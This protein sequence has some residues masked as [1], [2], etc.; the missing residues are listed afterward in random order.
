MPAIPRH[1]PTC[2]SSSQGTS[3]PPSLGIGQ[4]ALAPKWTK[5]GEL[6]TRTGQA[7]TTTTP[8]PPTP[9]PDGQ[10]SNP[11]P[12]LSTSVPSPASP[13]L[14]AFA[15]TE[16]L[17]LALSLE[18]NQGKDMVLLLTDSMAAYNS[19]LHI[20][21]GR[22]PRSGIEVRLALALASRTHLDTGISWMI[23]HRHPR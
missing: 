1:C 20:A 10:T 8:L 19:A 6:P 11:S 14:K 15:D 3:T 23:T 5:A 17:G 22:A 12:P 2:N 16:R 7:A 4:H 18:A 13:T 21:K 9:P